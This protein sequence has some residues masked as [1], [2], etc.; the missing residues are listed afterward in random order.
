MQNSKKD[1]HQQTEV[2]KGDHSVDQSNNDAQS[3]GKKN[4]DQ[5]PNAKHQDGNKDQSMKHTSS[6]D[7]TGAKNA[8][9]DQDQ[10]GKSKND[11]SGGHKGDSGQRSSHK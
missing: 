7:K 3:K 4:A 10:N 11:G 1:V 8:Q 6:E 5:Q 2:K 9:H